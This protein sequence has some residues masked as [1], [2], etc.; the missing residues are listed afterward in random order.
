ML[1]S[2]LRK[3]CYR[4][5]FLRILWNLHKTCKL[6]NLHNNGNADTNCVARNTNDNFSVVA[7]NMQMRHFGCNNRFAQIMQIINCQWK[8]ENNKCTIN[9][10]RIFVLD[11]WRLSIDIIRLPKRKYFIEWIT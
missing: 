2:I 3:I 9:V 11:F 1:I 8:T 7:Q 6:N 5:H 10:P 4:Y